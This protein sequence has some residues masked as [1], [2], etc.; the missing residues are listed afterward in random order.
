MSEPACPSTLELDGLRRQM[1]AMAKAGKST[2][3]A[4][5]A[6]DAADA[7]RTAGIASQLTAIAGQLTTMQTRLDALQPA[8]DFL[9]GWASAKG[10]A[11]GADRGAGH[12]LSAAVKG[13]A[14]KV[15]GDP[16]VVSTLTLLLVALLSAAVG[17]FGGASIERAQPA[18]PAQEAQESP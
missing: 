10:A 3:D 5:L 1:A 14:A 2:A 15:A 13:T 11:E 9:E 6:G 17:L 8:A 18:T 7:I 4:I 16:R 12:E